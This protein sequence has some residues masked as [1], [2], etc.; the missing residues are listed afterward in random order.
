ML[1]VL[2]LILIEAVL[3]IKNY[4]PGTYL[5]GWDNLMPELNF[6]ANFQR[7]IFGVWQ[8]YRGLGLVDGMSHIANLVHTFYI[9]ILSLFFPQNVLRYLGI[10]SLHFVGGLGM[11]L[12]AK[13]LIKNKGVAFIGALFYMLNLG[14]IQMF[15]APLETFAFHFAALP[16]IA[17]T[18]TNALEK[19]GRKNY[20]VLF[21]VLFLT[22]PQFFVPTFVIPTA[23]LIISIAVFYATSNNLLSGISDLI[24]NLFNRHRVKNQGNY[25][26]SDFRQND[27]KRQFYGLLTEARI[28]KKDDVFTTPGARRN[29]ATPLQA[30]QI[31]RIKNLLAVF[32]II[33]AANAFWLFPYLYGLGGNAPIISGA[34]INQFSSE[35]VFYRNRARGD[36]ANIFTLKGFMID[37]FEFDAKES[38]QLYFMD[39]WRKHAAT[40][41][42]KAVYL[43]LLTIALF[44]V[45]QTVKKRNKIVYPF[46][47]M[48][49]ASFFFL[50]NSVPVLSQTNNLIRFIFPILAEALRFPF[51]KFMTLFAFSL[52]IFLAAGITNIMSF[53]PCQPAKTDRSDANARFPARARSDKE[54]T[55]NNNNKN[56]ILNLIQNLY[57]GLRVIPDLIRNLFNRHRVKNQ[58]NYID[59]DF[60]QNDNKSQFYGFRVG[61]WNDKVIKPGTIIIIFL[62]ILFLSLPAFKGS[63]VSPLFRLEIPSDYLQTMAYL[64]QINDDK[65][66]ALLPAYTF[67]SWQYRSWNQRGSGFWWYGIK[68]PIMERAFD[69]WSRYNE[70]FYNEIAYAIN[71]EDVALFQKVATKYDIGYFLLDQYLINNLTSKPI[72][73]EKLMRFLS[74]CGLNKVREFGKIILYKNQAAFDRVYFLDQS[75][76]PSVFSSFSFAKKDQAFF[77]L[78]D[79]V[80]ADNPDYIYPFS[81]LFTEKTQTD[82]EFQAVNDKEKII[83]KPQLNFPHLNGAYNFL[84]PDLFES[85]YLIPTKFKISQD[86]LILEIL[87]PDVFINGKKITF[88]QRELVVPLSSIGK[89]TQIVLTDINHTIRP[90]EAS[91]LQN[92]YLNTIIL[93]NKESQEV[94]TIDT[95][96]IQKQAKKIK[97]VENINDFRVEIV[98]IKSPFAYEDIIKKKDYQITTPADA[99]KTAD[100]KSKDNFLAVRSGS[101]ELSFWKGNLPHQAS[102]IMF[103]MVENISGLPVSF[104]VDNPSEKRA[105]LEARLNGKKENILILPKSQDYFQEY[106][107]HFTVKSVG[108]ELAQAKIN[109][110]SLY[111]FPYET[112]KR[113][114][115]V[116]NEA[117]KSSFSRKQADFEKIASFIYR[118]RADGNNNLLVLSEAYHS[119][120]KAYYTNI[121]YQK[122]KI[123]N[124]FIT[125]FPFLFGTELKNHVLVNNWANGWKI[126]AQRSTL[127]ANQVVIIFWPQY[128]EFIG[129]GLIFLGILAILTNFGKKTIFQK[130]LN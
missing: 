61:V 27:N 29:A 128:L 96:K 41:S 85:E 14:I 52:S 45:A 82:L 57:N 130:F 78:G 38:K 11:Y 26:D 65:R 64:D 108:S 123:K 47:G 13:K 116:K 105:E 76:T 87:Y 9:W 55:Q 86:S 77:D 94:L 84:V 5:I 92:N 12:L 1:Y 109:D 114:K 20:L 79:Y 32:L 104:Y 83:I 46:L 16:F 10:F 63:F 58:R 107:F 19:P 74:D 8:D 72:N 110:F 91:Y 126:D 4:T 54:K 81:S 40:L 118:L 101:T 89:P 56:V 33:L 30:Q 115:L 39:V 3:L 15:Y 99:P 23:I 35:E 98:K 93:K 73:Y 49:G 112:L 117:I 102:Y 25:I 66:I 111:P 21:L 103:A 28:D 6:L 31:N 60:R 24:R 88:D 51:T 44:G 122:S 97:G 37:T 17:L 70:Q 36:L 18:V 106:G 34:R 95:A 71:T 69:P 80:T 124:L 68:Q 113:M 100:N 129:L 121:K 43:V 2:A 42:Y 127:N 119:G 67:W 62:A 59:S 48:L 7:S 22:T 75:K 53:R 90:G 125:I 120:W 50:A